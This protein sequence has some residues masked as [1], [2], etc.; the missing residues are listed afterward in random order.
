MHHEVLYNNK[1]PHLQLNSVYGALVQG[2][3]V[4]ETCLSAYTHETILRQILTKPG[5]TR[6]S[7]ALLETE[8]DAGRQTPAH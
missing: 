4:L 1:G 5:D 3:N 8:E 7:T 6:C 2:Q